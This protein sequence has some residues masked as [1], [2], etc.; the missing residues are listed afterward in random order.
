MED[1]EI[2]VDVLR[3]DNESSKSGDADYL[4]EEEDKGPK[5]CP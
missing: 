2:Q 1:V 4:G 5:A 3:R